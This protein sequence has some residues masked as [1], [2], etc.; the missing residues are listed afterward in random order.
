MDF[1]KYTMWITFEIMSFIVK[2]KQCPQ[3][4]RLKRSLPFETVSIMIDLL[5]ELM[6]DRMMKCM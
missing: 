1:H 6:S 2:R 4:G 5:I 3:N